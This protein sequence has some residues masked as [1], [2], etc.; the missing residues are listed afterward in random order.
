MPSLLKTST[1]PTPTHTCQSSKRACPDYRLTHVPPTP[2]PRTHT[3]FGLRLQTRWRG[4]SHCPRSG[5]H[6]QLDWASSL[7]LPH[8]ASVCRL[9]ACGRLLTS[10]RPWPPACPQARAWGNYS[11]SGCSSSQVA[12]DGGHVDQCARIWGG[13]FAS[14]LT[15]A[16][17]QN[18][19][20]N[21]PI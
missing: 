14:K 1:P 13:Q 5:L 20:Q 11:S 8:F 7:G 2:P 12:I 3:H 16:M 9:E 6:L 18:G 17:I 19:Q 21:L 4:P 15:K 10:H